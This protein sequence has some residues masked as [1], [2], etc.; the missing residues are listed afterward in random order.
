MSAQPRKF[1]KNYTALVERFVSGFGREALE[2]LDLSSL[3]LLRGEEREEAIA[4]LLEQLAANVNDPRVPRALAAMKA[5]Q[6]VPE[7]E[8]R[9]AV[10][11]DDTAVAS[12]EA[13]WRYYKSP[14]AAPA[15]AKILRTG[16]LDQPRLS[17]AQLLGELQGEEGTAALLAA[18]SDKV[19]TVRAAALDS[20]K[21]RTGLDKLPGRGGRLALLNARLYSSLA[22]V[23]EPA[24]Q[25][26]RSLFTSLQAGKTPQELGLG[27]EEAPDSPMFARL[28]NS[29][30][31]EGGVRSKAPGKVDLEAFAALTGPERAW[32]EQF[33]LQLISDGDPRG[34][35]AAAE[36]HAEWA[37]A[38]LR[39]VAKRR[40]KAAAA[41][42]KA[43]ADLGASA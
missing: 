17:A 39:E 31:G 11:D 28:R 37:V 18:L 16:Y 42:K 1:F 36:L 23:R 20:L 26:I 30:F 24:L 13:L 3:V 38:A 32:G 29:V 35:S 27:R 14:A 43:L 4:V 5:D 40:G 9:A 12:A 10:G 33:I 22:S 8:K 2:D 19:E 34:I 6:A 15:L 25:E 7:L 21:Q 41:A